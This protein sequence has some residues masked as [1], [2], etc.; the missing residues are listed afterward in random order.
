META[1]ENFKNDVGASS[2]AL[3]NELIT[4]DSDKLGHQA[5][6]STSTSPSHKLESPQTQN[7]DESNSKCSTS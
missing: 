6:R 1:I 5:C 4:N 7:I 3:E 2:K